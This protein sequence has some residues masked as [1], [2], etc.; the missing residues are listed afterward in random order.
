KVVEIDKFGKEKDF[1][2]EKQDGMWG[3]LGIKVDA[4]N[5]ILW[6]N[7]AAGPELK[8]DDGS[9]AL[10]KYDLKTRK[11]I[12]K[13][14]LDNK[15]HQAHLFN[16]L[17]INSKGDIFLTDSLSGTIYTVT[18][19][20]DELEILINPGEFFYPNGIT[21]SSDEKYL[22]VADWRAGVSLIDIEAKKFAILPHPENITLAG[23]DGLYF[24]R[25]SLIA[26][27]NG[28]KPER[29]VRFFLSERLDR[30][31]SEKILEVNNPLFIVPTTGLMLGDNFYYIANSQLDNYK[32]GQISSAEQLKPISILSI[33]F[34]PPKP[35]KPKATKKR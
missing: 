28:S 27:Q 6:V 23:I 18:S 22:F 33:S 1:A 35:T 3:V 14:V 29:V 15:S 20:K 13:Y 16:D 11:M 8:P 7:T 32:D 31:E 12:K 17:V 9:A 24:Y 25:N 34:T 19:D 26:V 4:K 10:F 21:I 2:V 5:R 30:V